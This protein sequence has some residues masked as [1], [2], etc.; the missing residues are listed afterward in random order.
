MELS[1]WGPFIGACGTVFGVAV[2]LFLGWLKSRNEAAAAAASAAVEAASLKASPYEA[3]AARVV[4]LETSDSAKHTQIVNLSSKVMTLEATS[5]SRRILLYRAKDRHEG[6]VAH[7]DNV[8]AWMDQQAVSGY[9]RL[10]PELRVP[11]P[12]A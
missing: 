3:L 12:T 9:P 4:Q 11:V 10:D 7:V 8:E 5:E 1:G 2:T 6:V